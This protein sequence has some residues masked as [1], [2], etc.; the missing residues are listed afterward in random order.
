MSVCSSLAVSVCKVV[1]WQWWELCCVSAAA[2]R[3]EV[4][5]FRPY[6]EREERGEKK[7]EKGVMMMRPGRHHGLELS[8]CLSPTPFACLSLTVPAHL[9]TRRP[10]LTRFTAPSRQGTDAMN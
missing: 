9:Q 1:A 5:E 6:T 4:S 8:C 10:F 3:G 2:Q 7:R